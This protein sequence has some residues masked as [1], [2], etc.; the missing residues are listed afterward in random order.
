MKVNNQRNDQGPFNENKEQNNG[1]HTV[2]PRQIYSIEV[3]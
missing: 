1:K 3:L 2:F